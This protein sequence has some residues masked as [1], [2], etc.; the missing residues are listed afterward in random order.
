MVLENYVVKFV[1]VPLA[2]YQVLRNREAYMQSREYKLIR[3]PNKD[4]KMKR[5]ANVSYALFCVNVAISAMFLLSN[6]NYSLK[7][8]M[9]EAIMSMVQ[10]GLLFAFLTVN[11]RL[12]AYVP[13]KGKRKSRVDEGFDDAYMKF[14]GFAIWL[15][16]LMFLVIEW[17]R[18][19]VDFMELTNV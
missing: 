17:S 6:S 16:G 18:F 12:L 1:L 14:G 11:F 13:T 2:M 19:W 4:V 9:F 5:S 3:D 10:T 7:R 15:F 8:W